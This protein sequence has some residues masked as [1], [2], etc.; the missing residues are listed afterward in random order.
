M[1]RREF[2]L[3]QD[4]LRK[5]RREQEETILWQKIKDAFKEAK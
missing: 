1:I 4:S 2:L 5:E 3:N